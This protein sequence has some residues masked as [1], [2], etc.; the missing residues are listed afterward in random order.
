M[1]FY[2]NSDVQLIFSEDTVIFDTVFTTVGS[3]T[4]LFK[5]KN[6]YSQPVLINRIYIAGGKDSDF[7]IN[8]DGASGNYHED[9]EIRAK[10][11]IYVFVE[12]TVDPNNQ[13]N[14]M[15]I[16]D[17]VIFEINGK[18]FDVDLVAWGQDA[19][20]YPLTIFEAGNSYTLAND[21]PHV[22]YGWAVVDSSACLILQEGTRL[23]FHKGS[24]ILVYKDACIKS[25]G[26]VENPV[27]IQGD[28]LEYD[29]YDVP[30][31]WER[32]WLSATSRDNVFQN[33]IIKNA[34][35]G[36]QVDSVGTTQ[37]GLP[38]LTLINTKIENMSGVGLLA[39]GSEVVAV[40]SVFA[41]CGLYCAAL[42]YGGSYEFIHCTF[43]NYW[44]H[45]ARDNGL[46]L[47]NNYYESV[48]KQIVVRD[49]TKA[50]FKNCI[51]YGNKDEEIELDKDASGTFN[52][53]FSYCLL[54]TQQNTSSAN[55]NNI[56]ANPSQVT[57]D[58][59]SHDPV[60]QDYEN[61]N[62][63]LFDQSAALNKGNASYTNLLLN[64]TSS[65]ND[66][67]DNPRSDG[68]PDLGAY[69]YIP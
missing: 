49:L 64:Y 46:L 66:I 14:P 57:V 11:S 8:V 58:G 39:Q 6:P 55:F 19:Y 9:V 48:N 47:L 34:N 40:N 36:I 30:N 68:A 65:T 42:I 13:T 41:N 35:V 28:R 50:D 45:S 18:M 43:A 1:P 31:Q 29:Y 25:L 60:F 26:T 4:K 38:T 37:E 21:K 59:N 51:V 54:K 33:T 22:F 56:T 62:Y 2:D 17:S 63:Q 7:R 27:I 20:F 5:V 16:T 10:D 44:S 32:I 61:Y 24:G 12:V 23:H 67:K 69:E 3:V 53:L 15:I 52:Y